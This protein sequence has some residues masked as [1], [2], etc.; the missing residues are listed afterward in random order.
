MNENVTRQCC[1]AD[2]LGSAG[3]TAGS[4]KLLKNK[5]LVLVVHALSWPSCELQHEQ[6][7]TTKG[8]DEQPSY[9]HLIDFVHTAEWA[10]CKLQIRELNGKLREKARCKHTCCNVSK[11]S[12]V[13]TLFSPPLRVCALILSTGRSL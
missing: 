10:S 12:I 6:T 7:K 1:T 11:K 5:A 2:R 8:T 13:T 9:E 4:H 3:L